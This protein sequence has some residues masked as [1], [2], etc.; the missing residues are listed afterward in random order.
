MI[1]ERETNKSK[2]ASKQKPALHLPSLN[3]LLT[4]GL[5]SVVLG[6]FSCIPSV[7]NLLKILNHKAMLNFVKDF[8]CLY[9]VDKFLFCSN[10]LSRIQR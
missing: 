7:L 3:V 2:Q 9:G 4:V 10:N 1:P 5:F 8:F 6:R